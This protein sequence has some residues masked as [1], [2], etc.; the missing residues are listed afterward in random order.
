[1][2]ETYERTILEKRAAELRKSTGNQNIHSKL[3]LPISTGEIFKRAIIRPF[4]LLF[5]SP[6]VAIMSVYVALVYAY[7]YFFF[8]TMSTVFRDQYH[9]RN[10]ILG[11]SFTGLGVGSIISVIFFAIVSDRLLKHLAAKSGGE[12]KPEYRLPPL[13]ISCVTIPIGLIWYGWS[14]EKRLHWI[15][16]II[17]T[18]F[19]GVGQI[20]TFMPVVTYLIDS[21][22]EYAASVS[23]A[24]TV[25]RSL[26]GAFIPLAGPPL[27]DALGLGWANS[28]LGFIAMGMIPV[29]LGLYKYGEGIRTNP[30]FQVKL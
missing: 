9:W 5:L 8:T 17:G 21:F 29:T 15:M 11:L 2:S 1:M 24:N 19:V 16:P 10:E 14:A 28:L 23:A 22:P 7:L 4:K 13:L 26:G 30:K 20:A 18:G 27:Y 12:R 6:I 25:L 3:A